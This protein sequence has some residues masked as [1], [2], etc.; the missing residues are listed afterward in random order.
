MAYDVLG[1][2][3]AVDGGGLG[4]A[5]GE[6]CYRGPDTLQWISLGAGHGRFVQAALSGALGDFY[7]DLRWPGWDREVS[8]LGADRGLSVYPPPFTAQGRDPGAASRRSVPFDEL[9]AFYDDMAA[10]I[11]NVDSGAEVSFR[12]VE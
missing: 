8:A 12:I 9:I 5:P 6:V 7:A 10:Q 1:G 3:F 11:A 2:V 4:V